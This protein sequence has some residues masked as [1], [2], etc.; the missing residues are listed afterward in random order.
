ML[1]EPALV[2]GR[3]ISLPPVVALVLL[4]LLLIPV[5]RFNQPLFQLLNGLHSPITDPVWLTLTTVGDGFFLSIILGA[6]MVKNPRVTAMGLILLVTSSVAIHVIKAVFPTP[7]P[8]AVLG[9]VHV[10]G[11]LLRSGSFPSG[12][13]ASGISAALAVWYC[14]DSRIAGLVT[15][16]VGVLIGLSRIFV[17]AHFP[18][19]VVAGAVCALGS[20]VLIVSIVWPTIKRRIPDRPNLSRRSFRVALRIETVMAVCAI[21]L[22]GP[23]CAESAIAGVAVGTAV[24]A[25]V[26]HGYWRLE[27][28]REA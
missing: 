20:F 14:F 11:P 8:A 4:F 12:H 22:W 26:A 3:F 27:R 15:F 2:K 7:R 24:L 6:F 16:I 1:A 17:G 21:V 10:V 25:F 23:Y 9:A 28:V 19:D 5:H 18:Q 13:T